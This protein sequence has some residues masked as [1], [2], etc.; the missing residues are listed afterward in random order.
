MVAS[1]VGLN[2]IVDDGARVG[3]D[4]DL[5]NL[6]IR[7][8]ISIYIKR[9]MVKIKARDPVF[10]QLF[11][12]DVLIP[13]DNQIFDLAVCYGIRSSVSLNHLGVTRYTGWSCRS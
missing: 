10:N 7:D 1:Y 11:L 12:F 9:R 2:V 8:G 5:M 4:C 13:G 6:C 3:G